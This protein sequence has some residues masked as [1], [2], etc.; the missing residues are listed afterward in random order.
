M[1]QDPLSRDSSS[2]KALPLIS[3]TVG[4]RS[5]LWTCSDFPVCKLSFFPAARAE[6]VGRDACCMSAD[7]HSPNGEVQGAS[8]IYS[9][10]DRTSI[11]AVRLR[12][13]LR[14]RPSRNS[15]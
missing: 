4:M 1:S 8:L 7:I 9:C 14:S 15:R 5:Q 12:R 6:K 11:Y 10:L 2:N 3:F 13:L